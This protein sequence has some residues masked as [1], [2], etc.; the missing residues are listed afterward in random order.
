MKF[1]IV[2]IYRVIWVYERLLPKYIQHCNLD[3]WLCMSRSCDLDV[4]GHASRL[5]VGCWIIF[6]WLSRPNS[7]WEFLSLVWNYI[8][9]KIRNLEN[10]WDDLRTRP[11]C[12]LRPR[13]ALCAD[14][15]PPSH[16]TASAVAAKAAAAVTTWPKKPLRG[17]GRGCGGAGGRWM[18][19]QPRR[20][21]PTRS[22]WP[23]LNRLFL[24]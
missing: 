21:R 17:I 15:L 10:V 14:L 16:L 11:P 1:S 24:L 7:A 20:R 4:Q 13:T 12:K 23:Q 6:C 2:S 3:V 22:A 8:F 19:K 5:H 18:K 9:S